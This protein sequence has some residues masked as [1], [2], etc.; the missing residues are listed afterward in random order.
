M[1]RVADVSMRFGRAR[2][3]DGVSLEVARG[4]AVAL[5]GANGAGKTTLIRCVLGL[6]RY[7]GCVEVAGLDARAH[8]KRVRKLIGYVPQEI[9]FFDDMRVGESIRF[10]ARLKAAPFDD[11]ERELDRVGLAGHGRKRVRE[12]SG[13]MKQRLA[14]AVALLGDPP[15]LVLDEVTASLDALGRDGFVHLLERLSGEGRTMLFSSHRVDEVTTLA[16][17]VVTMDLGKIIGMCAGSEFDPSTRRAGRPSPAS[18]AMEHS[19]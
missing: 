4:E 2:A 10:F 11:V 16:H 17:R 7:T 5:W 15:V 14:L 9:G 3:L 18:P 12:L 13:G 1:I 8:G 6:L 19:R